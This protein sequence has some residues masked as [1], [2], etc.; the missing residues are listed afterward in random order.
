MGSL[1]TA[2]QSANSHAD[3]FAN[4]DPDTAGTSLIFQG[5]KLSASLT[6]TGLSNPLYTAMNILQ[7]YTFWL[8][9]ITAK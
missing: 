3:T 8:T 4:I 1:Q 9:N 5:F 7:E 2:D 6:I